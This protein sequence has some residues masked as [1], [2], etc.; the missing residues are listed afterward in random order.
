MKK[1]IWHFFV[2]VLAASIIT[3]YKIRKLI[4]TKAGFKIQ[5]DNIFSNCYFESNKVI[6][7]ENSFVNSK[8]HF[9]NEDFVEIGRN[10]S[11][12]FQVV[13]CANS[14]KFGSANQRAGE[15]ISLP[16]KIGDGCWIGARVM[17]LPGVTI[18]DG[19]IIAAGSVVTKDCEPNG[20]F[21]GV[22]AK[23]IKD[24]PL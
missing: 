12:A 11:I 14:H 22:P 21:A 13:F 7:G 5:T 6:I 18:G 1:R 20:I 16:I 9:E 23:R 10:C 8:C 15:H 24:L 17:I 3:P 2:N 4:Y 19:C